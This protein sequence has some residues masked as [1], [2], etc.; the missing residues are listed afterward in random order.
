MIKVDASDLAHVLADERLLEPEQY[1]DF[2]D[3]MLPLCQEV[4]ILGRELVYRGWLSPFQID[5]IL[6]GQADTLILG[7][8]VLIEPLGEGGMGRVY[9]ARNWKINRLVAIKVIR[10]EQ[11]EQPAVIAR[12][13][14]EIRALGRVHHPNIVEALDAEFRPGVLFYAMEYFEGTD[15]GRYV[16]RDGPFSV[17]DAC[18]C[19]MQVADALQHA[20][21][22][23]LI[24]RD[25]KPSNLLL[26]EP[27]H[28]VKVLDLG[29]TR[30]ETPVNDSIFNELT[31]AGALIGTP[32]YMSPEQIKDSRSADIRSDLYSLGCTF[33]YLLTGVAPFE[34][35]DAM[36]DKL[37]AQCDTEPTPIR[38]LRPDVPLEIA[39]L[40]TRLM[41]KRRR[42]RF[43]TPAD[44]RAALGALI[45][46]D[47]GRAH[48]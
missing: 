41:A 39:A 45:E 25:I 27:D 15:L 7:S 30:C 18:A 47:M 31:R 16:R 44:L 42:D 48:V 37:W 23:G 6:T 35:L 28:I 12:F 17:S 8:Y 20:N 14:R 46:I 11:S 40:I 3:S 19:I 10:D 1:V 43:Q 21:E 26:T 2:V 24:H 9:L 33:Y 38:Q 36:V 29:L 34:H 22:L 5:R 4:P 13:Q 32:D